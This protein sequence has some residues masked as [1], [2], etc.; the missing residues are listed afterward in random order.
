MHRQARQ[1]RIQALTRRLEQAVG[2]RDLTRTALFEAFTVFAVTAWT[3][4]TDAATAALLVQRECARLGRLWDVA[5]DRFHAE[6]RDIIAGLWAQN[7]P[8]P[9]VAL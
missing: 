8:V 5:E 1:L 4:H 6:Y 7:A 2:Q 9:E 3:E